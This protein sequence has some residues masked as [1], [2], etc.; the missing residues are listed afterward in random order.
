MLQTVQNLMKKLKY[1]ISLQ[2]KNW[3]KILENFL[4]ILRNL[5]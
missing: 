2:L 5:L 3:I 1:F 4:K